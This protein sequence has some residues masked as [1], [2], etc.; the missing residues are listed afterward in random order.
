MD[1]A[2]EATSKLDG[3]YM[4]IKWPES[5][6]LMDEMKYSKVNQLRLQHLKLLRLL[7]NGKKLMVTDADAYGSSQSAFPR[8]IKDI[9]AS[10]IQ[11]RI[12]KI[13][14]PSQSGKLVKYSQYSL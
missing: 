9:K 3:I 13:L 1:I 12:D 5:Q 6:L 8:R 10:G 7:L 4:L 2:R 11:V 14:I